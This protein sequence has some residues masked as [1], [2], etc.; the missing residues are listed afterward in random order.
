MPAAAA[1][2]TG[3]DALDPPVGGFGALLTA[4]GAYPF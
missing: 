3:F 1:I 2:L 4:C